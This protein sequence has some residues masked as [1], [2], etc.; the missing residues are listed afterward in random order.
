MKR[1]II[2]ADRVFFSEMYREQEIKCGYVYFEKNKKF[3][4]LNQMLIDNGMAIKC[5]ETRVRNK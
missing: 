1:K 3:V 2:R 5:D 4:M